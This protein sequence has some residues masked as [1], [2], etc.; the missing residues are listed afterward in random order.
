MNHWKIQ[1]VTRRKTRARN[2]IMG[3]LENIHRRKKQTKR[4]QPVNRKQFGIF[5]KSL[6]FN[7]RMNE[8]NEDEPAEDGSP[9]STDGQ[10]VVR[11]PINRANKST[12]QKQ[13]RGKKNGGATAALAKSRM[14]EFDVVDL[15]DE[16]EAANGADQRGEQIADAKTAIDQCRKEPAKQTPH[17]NLVHR[18]AIQIQ[19]NRSKIEFPECDDSCPVDFKQVSVDFTIGTLDVTA[20]RADGRRPLGTLDVHNLP[21]YQH[22]TT[23]SIDFH[24]L[25]NHIEA[26][27]Y[28]SSVGVGSFQSDSVNQSF[29]TSV[30]DESKYSGWSLQTPTFNSE[31]LSS[32]MAN[33]TSFSQPYSNDAFDNS[34]PSV[35]S[36]GFSSFNSSDEFAENNSTFN[37][38][39]ESIKME[40]FTLS[41]VIG[42]K[43]TGAHRAY[44]RIFGSRVQRQANTSNAMPNVNRILQQQT[45]GTNRLQ[46]PAQSFM[47]TT[48]LFFKNMLKKPM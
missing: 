40:P 34:Q 6:T 36:D 16:N 47:P 25:E 31:E 45:N 29:C 22:K 23:S 15:I 48:S 39:G 3:L 32:G 17:P 8:N 26:N 11:R 10:I 42:R 27:N 28:K 30:S 5:A 19:K 18:N 41:M 35:S 13:T 1:A 37:G 20:Q 24:A 33:A 7:V 2:D 4:T 43:S 21:N 46:M 12:V 44:E 9:K 14:Q 38:F